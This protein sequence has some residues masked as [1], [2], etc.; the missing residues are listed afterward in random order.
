MLIENSD[1]ERSWRLAAA[2]LPGGMTGREERVAVNRIGAIP[3]L[4]DL[5]ASLNR[6][7]ART[8]D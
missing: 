3:W 8:N 5:S 2:A 1:L 7:S 4:G 6:I